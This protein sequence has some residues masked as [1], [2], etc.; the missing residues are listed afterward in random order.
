MAI[1]ALTQRP[2]FSFGFSQQAPGVAFPAAKPP[3]QPAKTPL[4][5]NPF[6]QAQFKAQQPP[7]D[8]LGQFMNQMQGGFLKPDLNKPALPYTASKGWSA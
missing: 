7:A 4:E 2:Q 6:R 3:V 5:E 8:Q 1:R